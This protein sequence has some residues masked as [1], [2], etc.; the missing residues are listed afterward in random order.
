[1]KMHLVVASAAVLLV[2]AASSAHA[3]ANGPAAQACRALVDT[4]VAPTAFEDAAALTGSVSLTKDEFE[5]T[6]AY[7]ARLEAARANVPS[8][9]VIPI[10]LDK[11]HAV[12][13]ADAGKFTISASAF[14]RYG[15]DWFSA[16]YDSGSGISPSLSSQIG[17]VVASSETPTGTYE[18]QNAY[19]AKWDIV[20]IERRVD[21]IYQGAAPGYNIGLFG[22]DS[23]PAVSWDLPVPPE[24]ARAAKESMRAAVVVA[25][26]A[27]FYFENTQGA[28]GRI[29]IQNPRDVT[30]VARVLVADIQCVVVTDDTNYVFLAI[31][32]N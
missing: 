5:T 24:N 17:L 13:N 19:G 26:A 4:R 7:Q 25:P 23:F 8:T 14:G 21:A 12:Y 31:P 30:Q 1:M 2:A 29:T 22:R 10:E 11:E 15:I 28:S 27:P 18:G 32:T 16:F 20:K 9:F 6:A 3:Q